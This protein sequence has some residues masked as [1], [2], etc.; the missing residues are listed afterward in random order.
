[1]GLV[2][3]SEGE[4]QLTSNNSDAPI[5]DQGEEIQQPEEQRTPAGQRI[6]RAGTQPSRC[7]LPSR[8]TPATS[9]NSIVI[10]LGVL[11]WPLQCV[12]S[13]YRLPPLLQ[14]YPEFFLVFKEAFQDLSRCLKA[15]I[16]EIGLP[17]I[18]HLSAL[19]T[20]HF[21]LPVLP[22]LLFLYF[23]ILSVLLLLLLIILFILVFF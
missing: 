11:P 14:F 13:P 19:S 22:I 20:F 3:K 23:F 2:N 21:H 4:Q 15:H 8:R 1:M 7:R 12:A 10:F 18:L 6:Q 9:I 17:I 16:K 5:E